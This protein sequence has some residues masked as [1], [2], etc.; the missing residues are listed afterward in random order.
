LTRARRLFAAAALSP[1][2][3]TGCTDW[4]GYDL[5]YFWGLIPALATMRTSVGFDPYEMPRLPPEHSVPIS[6]EF[7]DLPAPFQQAQLDSVAATLSNPFAGASSPEL[8]ARGESLYA[9]Q[10]AV[11]HGP[12]GAGNGPVIGAGKFPYAPPLQAGAAVVRSDGY[13]YGV[14]AVGR[15]LMPAYG[16]KLNHA[17]RWAL[18]AYMRELQR[19]AGAAGA[20]PAAAP[21]APAAPTDSPVVVQP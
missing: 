13:L 21:A 19:A 10:C 18:V 15:G 6:S 3:L 5:D 2:L 4:G 17:D 11:C 12:T 7:G 20:P 1:V 16:E 9:V 8:L 14:I